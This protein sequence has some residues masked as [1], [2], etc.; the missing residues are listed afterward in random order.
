M[1]L[2]PLF[3]GCVGCDQSLRQPAWA[4][5]LTGLPP[6]LVVTA[7]DDP[8]RDEGEHMPIACGRRASP[9]QMTRWDGMNHGFFA[10]PGVVDKA[11]AAIDEACVWVRSQLR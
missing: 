10:V 4:R 2:G 1:V 11:S 9:T 8:L 5:D 3:G 6:A 7:V